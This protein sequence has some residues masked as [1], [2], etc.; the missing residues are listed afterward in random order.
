[1]RVCV[2]HQVVWNI[3]QDFKLEEPCLSACNIECEESRQT[4]WYLL[5][6]LHSSAGNH[7]LKFVER[8][9]LGSHSNDC[10]ALR[11]TAILKE[12]VNFSQIDSGQQTARLH[13]P[14]PPT[15]FIFQVFQR[16]MFFLKVPSP[17]KRLALNIKND[18]K[19]SNTENKTKW[20]IN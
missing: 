12:A 16:S 14:P 2:F 9:A 10:R 6:H 15:E 7:V 20:K 3:T 13:Y 5:K 1:M 11:V 8:K 4:P 17:L 18:S 19:C